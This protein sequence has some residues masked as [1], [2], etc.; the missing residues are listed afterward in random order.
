MKFVVAAIAL[1]GLAWPAATIAGGVAVQA[2]AN[3]VG[4]DK[5]VCKVRRKTGSR[6][7]AKTCRTAKQWE[8]IAE[9]NRST[10]KDIVD[11]P[12]ISTCRGE[13]C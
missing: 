6:L 10:L 3:D 9:A 8:A 1:G 4:S 13:A 7:G 5:A 12:Q 11:R 2:S